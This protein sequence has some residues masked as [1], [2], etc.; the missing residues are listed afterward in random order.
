[1]TGQMPRVRLYRKSQTCISPF[2]PWQAVPHN[3]SAAL[4]FWQQPEILVNTRLRTQKALECSHTTP[5]IPSISG[6]VPYS[7][8]SG[9]TSPSPPRMWA[10]QTGTYF[11]VLTP[12][13]RLPAPVPSTCA[14]PT[15]AMGLPPMH[16]IRAT[17]VMSGYNA[18]EIQG[19]KRYSRGLTFTT[20]FTWSNSYDFG[21]HNAFDQF[22]TNLEPWA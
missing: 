6:M 11:I 2:S 9:T 4:K 7:T 19:Q 3:L 13:L 12:T 17:R 22:Q 8:S 18:L 15:I 20:A 1:M 14:S 5:P 10:R 21:G 16:T